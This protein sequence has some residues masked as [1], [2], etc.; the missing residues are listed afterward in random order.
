M[1]I[2]HWG[3]KQVNRKEGLGEI[4][5]QGNIWDPVLIRGSE[6]VLGKF[7]AFVLTSNPEQIVKQDSAP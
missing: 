6:G 1:N 5:L 4:I 3:W 7:G 2:S